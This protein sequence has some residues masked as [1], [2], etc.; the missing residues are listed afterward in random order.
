VFSR[1]VYACK[2]TRLSS[3]APLNSTVGPLVTITVA[4]KLTVT[5]SRSVNDYASERR[6][7]MEIDT[8]YFDL[9]FEGEVGLFEAYL[10]NMEGFLGS[11]ITRLKAEIKDTIVLDEKLVNMELQVV[12]HHFPNILR[13]SFVVSLYSFLEHR[14]IEECW[15]R[16]GN[17]ILLNPSDIR[18]ID[19]AR[20][21][22]T[23]VL[24]VNFPSDSPEWEEIQSI[25]RLRNCI[26]HNHGKCD[27]DKFK[28]LRDYVAQNSDTLS[29]SGDE[30]VLSGEFC[31][32]ALHAVGKFVQRLSAVN[33]PPS[34]TKGA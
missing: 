26:V 11:E 4:H 10:Q 15:S 8:E 31:E 19:R 7:T 27:G 24:R 6:P 25:R 3:A 32:Q 16:K 29:L 23:K 9:E 17:D 14:L 12:G 22:L 28:S 13:K 18:G 34:I 33:K 21:Y 20:V 30:I 2:P 1:R 5:L